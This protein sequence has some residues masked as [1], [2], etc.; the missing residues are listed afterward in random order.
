MF[1]VIKQ[2]RVKFEDQ[3]LHHHKGDPE[4]SF[5]KV[6]G[7]WFGFESFFCGA[8]P[9]MTRRDLLYLSMQG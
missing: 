8:Y 3:R 2:G 5:I 6:E 1:Y 9:S 4:N 7:E